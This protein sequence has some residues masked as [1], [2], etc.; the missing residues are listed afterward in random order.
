MLWLVVTDRK[1]NYRV[2]FSFCKVHVRPQF[3][4]SSSTLLKSDRSE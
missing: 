1:K 3:V 2:Q 4:F